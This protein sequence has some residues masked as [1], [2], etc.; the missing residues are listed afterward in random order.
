MEPR[1]WYRV[2]VPLLVAVAI[3]SGLYYFLGAGGPR[4]HRLSLTGGDALGRRHELAVHLADAS[5]EHGLELAVV[6]TEGSADALARVAS[7]EIDVALVQGGIPPRP[8]APGG[9]LV[10]R[11]P[12]PVVA[13]RPGGR[14][15]G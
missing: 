1:L 10:R 3:G 11:T 7:G 14:R 8:G 12:A 13:I 5:A 15:P 6:P 4:T 2:L 9:R